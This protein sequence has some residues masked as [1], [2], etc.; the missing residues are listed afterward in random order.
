LNER[1]QEENERISLL[2]LQIAAN[3][4]IHETLTNLDSEPVIKKKQEELQ[5]QLNQH[6]QQEADTNITIKAAPLR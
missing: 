5:N 3:E 4:K 2:K 6:T 1:L